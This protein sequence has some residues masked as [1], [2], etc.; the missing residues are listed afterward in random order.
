VS[1]ESHQNTGELQITGQKNAVD[2][3][4]TSLEKSI[5]SAKVYR[6]QSGQKI[7][8]SIFEN[9]ANALERALQDEDELLIQVMPYQLSHQRRVAYE[10][11]DRK[12][13]LAFFF[14]ENGIQFIK[15]R[16]G[17]SRDDIVRIIDLMATDFSSAEHMDEDLYSLTFEN[18]IDHFDIIGR[19][20]ISERQ[21]NEPE[22]KTKMKEFR[23]K[24]SLKTQEKEVSETRK[25]RQDDL[26]IIEEF[27]LSTS[28]F[29]RSDEEVSKIVKSFT[30]SQQGP[31][32]ER[33]TLERLALMGFHFLLREGDIEQQQIGRDLVVQVALM[34]LE[35]GDADV[36]FALVRKIQQFHQER[37]ELRGEFQKILDSIFHFE[38]AQIFSQ[39]L[40]A[41]DTQKRLL[42]V[43]LSGPPSAVC[44]MI[45]LLDLA[46]WCPRVFKDFILKHSA[47]YSGW[48][49]DEVQ[50][51]PDLPC[52]EHL[53]NILV[54]RPNQQFSN[55][56]TALLKSES[57]A[58]RLKVLRQCATIGSSECLQSFR[59]LIH[60]SEEEDR[61]MVYELLPLA[62]NRE[63]LLILKSRI[64]SKEFPSCDED[65]KVH[66]YASILRT[67]G[68]GAYPWLETLWL[69]PG[70][71]VFKSR[72]LA[73]RRRI[74][75]KAVGASKFSAIERLVEKTP[76][77]ELSEELREMISRI[78][79]QNSGEKG[80]G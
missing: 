2:I 6:Y 30:G 59:A 46:P 63:A 73:E 60:S 65:E 74:L 77:S 27:R 80:E 76:A 25:L 7:L 19:D 67:A 35:G 79:Q 13:S 11:K 62:K 53:L 14:F 10:N 9:T 34:T 68:E 50:R 3:F 70:E 20:L 24:V 33:E 40:L 5:R 16:R 72:N 66:A 22:L 15:I 47:D 21:K 56:L 51:V 71:G 12:N 64:E 49:Q 41:K 54:T 32:R 31:R 55:F 37:S 38:R 78:S 39:V 29:S 28:Q 18:S 57:Q 23:Q 45:L 75:L 48:L 58:V 26:K 42:E 52:W 61:M 43:M 36:F 4:L 17:L 8:D 44:L 69:R 1:E